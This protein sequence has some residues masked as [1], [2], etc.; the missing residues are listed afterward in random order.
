MKVELDQLQGKTPPLIHMNRISIGRLS[1]S[2]VVEQQQP[3]YVAP[4]V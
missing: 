4:S 3:I 1:F 2:L